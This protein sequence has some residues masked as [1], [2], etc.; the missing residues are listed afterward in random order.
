MYFPNKREEVL[1]IE[2]RE[3]RVRNGGVIQDMNSEENIMIKTRDKVL[4]SYGFKEGF[5]Q[6]SCGF[7]F[8]IYHTKSSLC[9]RPVQHNLFWL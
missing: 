9:D 6:T 3:S 4:I 2:W 8:H 1:I 5:Y 7:D